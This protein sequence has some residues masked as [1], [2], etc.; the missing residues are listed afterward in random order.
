MGLFLCYKIIKSVSVQ[1]LGSGCWVL[2][3]LCLLCCPAAVVPGQ[4]H[5]SVLFP[6]GAREVHVVLLGGLM[7]GFSLERAQAEIHWE[8]RSL[9]KDPGIV[10]ILTGEGLSALVV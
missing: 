2:V 3:V 8:Q 10:L 6:A 5:G 7:V 9:E 1:K 4:S